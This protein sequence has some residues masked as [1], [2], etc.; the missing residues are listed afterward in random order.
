MLKIDER[1]YQPLANHAVRYYTGRVFA[2]FFSE[3]DIKDLVEEVVLRMWSG[4]DRYDES[5]GTVSAWVGTIS[6]NVVLDAVKREKRR[7]S[8]FNPAPLVE[9]SDEE[10]DVVGF[11]PVA[12]DETD[13]ETVARDTERVFRESVPSGRK[14]RLLDGLIQGCDASEMAAAENVSTAAIYTAVCNLRKQLKVAV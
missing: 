13:A 4:R 8:L 9:Q 5:R 6:R 14:A 2:R 12:S 1:E 3:D 11:V 7:R 10:G